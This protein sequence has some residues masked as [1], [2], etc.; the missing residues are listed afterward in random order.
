MSTAAHTLTRSLRRLGGIALGHVALIV[1]GIVFLVPFAWLVSTSLKADPQ[2]FVFPPIWMPRPVLWRNYAEALR[3]IHFLTYL[4]N[5]TYI[6]VL[7]VVGT[8]VSS[9]LVAYSFSRLR[10]PGRDALFLVALATMM[11]PFQVTL[12]PLVILFERMGWI[13][14]FRPLWVPAFLGS[15]FFIFLLRQFFMTIPQ[16]LSDAARI[17]GASEFD[18]YWRVILPLAKPALATVIL[19]AFI[20]AWND[21]LGPLIFLSDESNYTLA[22]GLQQFQSQ[23]ESEWAYLMAVSTVISLPVIVLFFFTQRTFIRGIALTG[24]KG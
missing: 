23:H 13:G 2:I 9:S 16:E 5:T 10:W 15:A 20:G 24:L 22:L 14:S 8:A 3:Y 6:C 18:I 19:F 4:R 11:V 1:C 7:V 21:F 12:I 17:D